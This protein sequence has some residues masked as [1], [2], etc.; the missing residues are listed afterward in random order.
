MKDELKE[1]YLNGKY[2]IN[3]DI[4]A[5]MLMILSA[6]G[7]EREWTNIIVSLIVIPLFMAYKYSRFVNVSKL[8]K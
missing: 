7:K 5:I 3:F 8:L 6:I 1:S 4:T 2:S